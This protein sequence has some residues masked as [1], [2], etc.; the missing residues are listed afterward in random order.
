MT[1]Q[2][3]IDR[4]RAA[5]AEWKAELN[6]QWELRAQ[7]EKSRERLDQ[8]REKYVS[9]R[10]SLVHY[11]DPLAQEFRALEAQGSDE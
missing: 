7:L 10:G 2:E 4:V 6:A 9:A 1:L 5:G 3:A 11:L 8:L